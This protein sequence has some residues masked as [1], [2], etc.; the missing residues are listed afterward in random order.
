MSAAVQLSLEET[1]YDAP[2]PRCD[3]PVMLRSA[4]SGTRGQDEEVVGVEV[5]VA[6]RVAGEQLPES[7]GSQRQDAA[8]VGGDRHVIDEVANQDH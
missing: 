6:R 8:H 5:V 4:S 3:I 2:A 7:P 1:H